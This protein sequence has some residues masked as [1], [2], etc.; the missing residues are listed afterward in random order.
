MWNILNARRARKRSI[1]WLTTWGRNWQSTSINVPDTDA[2]FPIVCVCA[3]LS[4]CVCALCMI[5]GWKHTN[6]Q[7]LSW[8]QANRHSFAVLRSHPIREYVRVVRLCDSLYLNIYIYDIEMFYGVVSR[9]ILLLHFTH[10]WINNG[11]TNEL[12]FL[13]YINLLCIGDKNTNNKKRIYILVFSCPA[14]M[15][16]Y[17]FFICILT[18]DWHLSAACHTHFLL[19]HILV[20]ADVCLFCRS[21][22]MCTCSNIHICRLWYYYIV[23]RW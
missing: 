22:N 11:W 21:A 3:Y 6:F 16:W 4:M 9:H 5:I 2:V 17:G 20:F 13:L 14:D 23:L 12:T 19:S 7:Q 8:H 1:E 15:T 10:H 18:C